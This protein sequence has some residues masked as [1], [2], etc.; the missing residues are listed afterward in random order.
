MDILEH[1]SGWVLSA[2]IKKMKAF[3]HVALKICLLYHKFNPLASSLFAHG[4]LVSSIAFKSLM[5]IQ[6]SCKLD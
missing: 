4:K 1:F 2:A 5:F 6:Y 3:N